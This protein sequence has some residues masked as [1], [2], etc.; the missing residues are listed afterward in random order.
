MKITKIIYPDM[1]DREVEHA[2]SIPGCITRLAGKPRRRN[3]RTTM[4]ALN[5][6]LMD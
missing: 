3:E 5:T 2:A 4:K 1:R 6:R